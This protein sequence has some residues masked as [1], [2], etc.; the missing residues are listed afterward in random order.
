MD[1]AKSA[2]HA[3]VKTLNWADRGEMRTPRE[4]SCVEEEED[5]EEEEV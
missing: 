2:V 1:N 5:D 4:A 3:V